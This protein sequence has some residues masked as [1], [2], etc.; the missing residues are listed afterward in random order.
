MTGFK[1][2]ILLNI[3]AHQYTTTHKT[4]ALSKKFEVDDCLLRRIWDNTQSPMKLTLPTPAFAAILGLALAGAPVTLQAQTQAAA[5]PVATTTPAPATKPATKPKKT[6]YS[7]T[8]TAIDPTASTI[9]V[10]TKK[11]TRTI[12]IASTTK[13]KKDKKPATLADFTVG[14]KV[15]GSYTTDASGKLT[16]YSLYTKTAVTTKPATGTA[17]AAPAAAPVTNPAP[18]TQ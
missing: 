3:K 12:A 15:T 13:I 2:R 5:A 7:G 11:S 1:K 18:A 6:E 8:L 14:I 17:P 16:A 4:N 9:T 10:T